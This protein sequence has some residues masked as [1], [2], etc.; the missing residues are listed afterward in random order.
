MNGKNYLQIGL[1]E[2]KTPLNVK[3]ANQC[4]HDE[5]ENSVAALKK[6]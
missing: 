1:Q 2:V 4:F 6:L 3:E 5:T